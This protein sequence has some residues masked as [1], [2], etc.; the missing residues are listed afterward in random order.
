MIEDKTPI[1]IGYDF[2]AIGDNKVRALTFNLNEIDLSEY[3]ALS[4]SI[5]TK[6]DTSVEL[7]IKVQ[8]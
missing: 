7:A 1:E 8:I 6:V 5:R 4:L 2:S 3:N